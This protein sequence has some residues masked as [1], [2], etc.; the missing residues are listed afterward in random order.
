M[1]ESI[2]TY[3]AAEDALPWV[4]K[5]HAVVAVLAPYD[6]PEAVDL[7]VERLRVQLSGESVGILDSSASAPEWWP[8]EE[9]ADD[10]PADF[11]GFG[12][13]RR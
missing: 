7:Q 6:G 12:T 1:P 13:P 2:A 10:E 8:T 3:E 4:L 11:G 9:D 5:P